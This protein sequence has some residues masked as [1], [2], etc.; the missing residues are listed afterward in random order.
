MTVMMAAI[1]VLCQRKILWGKG[2]RVLLS[3]NSWTSSVRWD[4]FWKAL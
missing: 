3:W 1:G 2:W 4:Q